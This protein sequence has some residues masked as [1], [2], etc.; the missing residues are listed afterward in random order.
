L[1][2][3]VPTVQLVL[4]VEN[5]NQQINVSVIMGMQVLNVEI[6]INHCSK[7]HLRIN[8]QF[9]FICCW[10]LCC[11]IFLIK[12]LFKLKIF[13][14]QFGQNGCIGIKSVGHQK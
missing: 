1:D 2:N 12:I 6:L 11:F 14:N 13:S 8:W 7:D 4:A 3:L 10:L 9:L 5:A